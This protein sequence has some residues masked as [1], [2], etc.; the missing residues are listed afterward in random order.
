VADPV[1]ELSPRTLSDLEA[2]LRPNQKAWAWDFY[3]SVHQNHGGRIT[4]AKA[5]PHG[6]LFQVILPAKGNRSRESHAAR[7]V[8]VTS[9]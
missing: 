7:D 8:S 9:R 1:L 4:V 5:I 2:F 6:S 3:L